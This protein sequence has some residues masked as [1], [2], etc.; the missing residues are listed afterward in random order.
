LPE[1]EFIA[2]VEKLRSVYNKLIVVVSSE[3]SDKF[4][5]RLL[6]NNIFTLVSLPLYENNVEDILARVIHN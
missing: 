6:M 2:Y 1:D 4:K 5:N 3:F